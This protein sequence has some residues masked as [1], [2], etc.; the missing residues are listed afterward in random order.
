M[1]SNVG[2][3]I[4]STSEVLA[5]LGIGGSILAGVYLLGLEEI[6]LGIMLLTVVPITM[7]LSSLVLYGFGQLV[8]KVDEGVSS[9]SKPTQ[10]NEK[11]TD[12]SCVDNTVHSWKCDKC[13]SM[14]SEEPCP[15]CSDKTEIQ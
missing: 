12:D 5:F 8:E 13:G 14:I 15:Y 10:E 3:K 11:T 9:L 4:K 1:Y 2:G 6:F 7:W